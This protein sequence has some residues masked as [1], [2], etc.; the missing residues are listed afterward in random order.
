MT[1]H[2]KFPMKEGLHRKLPM[3]FPMKFPMKIAILGFHRHLTKEKEPDYEYEMFSKNEHDEILSTAC[4]FSHWKW[5]LSGQNQD[6]YRT[7]RFLDQLHIFILIILMK[8]N[9]VEFSHE[10]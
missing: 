3:T 6:L 7:V 8:Q 1:F 10:E 4:H 2:M 5:H 9:D